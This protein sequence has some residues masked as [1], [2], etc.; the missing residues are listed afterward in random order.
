M[1]HSVSKA[2][3]LTPEQ[4][5]FAIRR[6]TNASRGH[7]EEKEKFRWSEVISVFTSVH[8]Y[9]LMIISFC[10]GIS[11]YSV[12]YFLPTIISNFGYSI[13]VT[14]L[15][16]V[17]PYVL[18]LI[19]TFV[20]SI[21]SD[22][23]GQRSPF[24]IFPHLLGIT[25]VAILYTCTRD[26]RSIAPRYFA[27]FL[28][29]GGIYSAV[30]SYLAWASNNFA[31]HY[32]RATALGCMIFMTNSGG[33]ASTWL[34]RTGDSPVYTTGYTVILTLLA[35]GTITPVVLRYYFIYVNKRR[36]HRNNNAAQ[37]AAVNEEKREGNQSFDDKGDRSDHFIYTI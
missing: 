31:P 10:S 4:R 35:L 18:S 1:P 27:I 19:L 20:C 11:V 3:F 6:L 25:G 26:H 33:L 2:K 16:T 23:V 15:L 36:K 14:Q 29:V 34:F 37:P 13:W 17:P 22:R 24:I 5:T 9:L 30:P 7:D 8:I 28:I 32:R 21:W 12:A